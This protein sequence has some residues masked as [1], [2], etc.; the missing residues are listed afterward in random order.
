MTLYSCINQIKKLENKD[1]FYD[2]VR[3]IIGYYTGKEWEDWEIKQLQRVADARYLEI[4]G[5]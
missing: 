1:G 5:R 3:E 4:G 2:S